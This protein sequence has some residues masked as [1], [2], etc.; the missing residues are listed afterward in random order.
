M[1]TANMPTK[2]S[3]RSHRPGQSLIAPL[4]ILA[5][6]TAFILVALQAWAAPEM[7]TLGTKE[8][9]AIFTELTTSNSVLPAGDI[10]I[11]NFTANPESITLPPGIQE[12]QVV[13]QT[14]PKQLGRKTIVV[15]IIIAGV[16]KEQVMLSGKIELYGNVVCSTKTLSRR[17][18]IEAGDVERVRRNITMLGPD[19]ADDA[20][21]VLGQELKTTLQPGAVLYRRFLKS[22]E[23]VKRGDI[24]SIQAASG[25]LAIS[26]PGRVQSA[27]A[28]GD[29]IK[30]KN[31]MSRREIYARVIGADTVQVDL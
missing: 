4:R 6:T 13:S 17:T 9:L 12:F 7:T 11:A 15:N 26:V 21:Q 5:A 1:I 27:G 22:P 24:V 3:R 25:T 28:K 29:L 8:L 20:E 23:T 18:I 30:V 16:A 19:L 14:Q 2:P 10:E 31:L